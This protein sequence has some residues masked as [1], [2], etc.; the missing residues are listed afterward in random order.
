MKQLVLDIRPDAPPTLENF[1]AGANAELVATV[2]LLAATST[3]RQLPARHVYVWGPA[4]SGRSHLLRASIALAR[5]SGR[6]THL[7]AAD[8]VDDA[9]PETADALVA[10]DDIDRLSPEAQVALFNAFNRSRGNGQSLLLAGPAA[11]LGLSLREDLRTRIGQSLVYEVQPLDDDS[12]ATILATLAERRGLRLA[13]EV[14][15][16]LLRHGR[17]ELPSLLAVLD[18]LDAASLERK[19]PITLPLLR[20]MMQQGLQI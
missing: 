12:R 19:R 9:L 11:P 13:D 7:L 2:S 16:F 10:V 3:A 1:V 15:D 5:E 17:R 14:V 20:E 6:P 8:D 4:G 18:A